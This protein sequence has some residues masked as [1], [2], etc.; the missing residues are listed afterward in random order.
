MA[1]TQWRLEPPSGD[2]P[3]PALVN[4]QGEVFKVINRPAQVMGAAGEVRRI[5]DQF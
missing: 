2:Q 4:E 1:R 5:I 3:A